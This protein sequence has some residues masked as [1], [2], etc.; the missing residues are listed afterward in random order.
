VIAIVLRF[1]IFALVAAF[2]YVIA[3]LELSAAW[4]FVCVLGG[5]LAAY[6]L[7]WAGR[8]LLDRE[9]TP[10]NAKATTMPVHAAILVLYGAAVIRALR[11]F[12]AWHGWTIPAPHAVA[13]AFFAA[14]TIAMSLAVANLAL[15]AWGAPFAIVLSR[16]LATDWLY[17]RTR[18]PMVLTTI[19]WFVAIGVELHS[20]SFV[21]WT[22]FVVSPAEFEYLKV[23]EER[24]L[25]IRF[26]KDYLAYKARTPFLWPRLG[27]GRE[28]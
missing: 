14:T 16:K 12:T 17:R 18:N 2:W 23:Y 26:G 28:A 11:L 3:R 25:E 24:E 15:K 19:L 10:A 13:D 22:L 6:P 5:P 27:R 20:A 7:V 4:N 1:L 9:P 8:F 21:F